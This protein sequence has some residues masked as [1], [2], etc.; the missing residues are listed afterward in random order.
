MKR[1]HQREEQLVPERLQQ[2]KKSFCQCYKEK[3][4]KKKKKNPPLNT[5]TS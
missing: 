3:K 4:K 1:G 2:E 5:G